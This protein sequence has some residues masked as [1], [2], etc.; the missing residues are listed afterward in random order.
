MMHPMSRAWTLRVIYAG[1]SGIAAL[2]AACGADPDDAT[3]TAIST[4]PPA[5]SSAPSAT[6]NPVD[7]TT[8]GAT[9]ATVATS[10]AADATPPA[11][12]PATNV[13]AADVPYLTMNGTDLAL[14]VYSTSGA[15]QRPVIVAFHGLS[16]A[17]KDAETVTVVAEAA[18]EAGFVVFVPSWIAGDPLPI[19]VETIAEL[20]AAGSCAVAFAQEHATMYGGDPSNTVTYGFSAGTGP[21]F[22]TAV[23]P[24][25]TPIAGCATDAPPRP[26]GGVVVGEGET[27]W[28]SENFDAA[29]D[30]GLAAMQDEVT[31]LI[32]PASWSDDVD[33]EF[34]V[35]AASDGTA[36][37]PIDDPADQAGWLAQR[38]PDGSIRADLDRVGAFD[39]DVIDY[40]DGARLLEL[41]LAEAGFEVSFDRHP[42]GHDTLDK[43]PQLIESIA[44]AAGEA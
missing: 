17:L 44:A 14:D 33:A 41:R 37:R 16:T 8:P 2:L 28:Q 23:A 39:D 7:A 9:A 21:A 36:P 38:D 1:L 15:G 3:N 10:H 42:G 4:T 13:V 29:F 34:V 18:A 40:L 27:F 31:T 20:R 5:D 12:A 24:A 30:E 19:D 35:W 6:S 26:V 11:T 25:G 32:D 43:V 22:T